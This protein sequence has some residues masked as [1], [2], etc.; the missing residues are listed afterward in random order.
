VSSPDVAKPPHPA[1]GPDW[2]SELVALY[3]SDAASQFILHG[4]L[5]DRFVLQSGVQVSLLDL[6]GFLQTVLLP[7]FDVELSYDLGNG[8]RVERGGEVLAQWQ[9]Y[10]DHPELPKSPRAAIEWLTRYLRYC[11]N[12]GRLGQQRLHVACIVKAANLVAPAA[13]AAGSP[14]VNALACSCANGAA[15]RCLRSTP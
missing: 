14:D 10:K 11:A 3:E 4:N 2:I 5:H 8:V 7:R 9:G 6:S 15:R 12:L 1:R 13:H